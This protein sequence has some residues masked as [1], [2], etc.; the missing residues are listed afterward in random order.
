[1]QTV[2]SF[3]ASS[4]EP[5]QIRAI[6]ADYLALE[7]ARVYR[8]LFVSRFAL[9]ALLFAV[10]GLGLH[11]LSPFALWSS[12]VLCAIAPAWAGFA[13]VRCDWRLERRLSE[14]PCVTEEALVPAGHRKVIKSS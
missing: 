5:E 13:E 11:W 4:V 9:L 3:H 14:L 12:L 2:T 7:R 6:M 10:V 8:R 1:M